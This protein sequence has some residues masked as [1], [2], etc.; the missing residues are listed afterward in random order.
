MFVA[1]A[2]PRTA[3]DPR[4]RRDRHPPCWPLMPI[5]SED[6]RRYGVPVI[7]EDLDDGLLRITGI[8]EKPQAERGPVR[9]RRNRWLRHHARRHRRTTRADQTLVRGRPDREIYLTHAINAY[10][11]RPCRLRPGHPGPLS[12]IPATPPTIWSRS[13]PSRWPIPNTAPVLRDLATQ[14]DGPA[15]ATIA[16]EIGGDR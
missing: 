4:L 14:L 8:V 3:A 6:S 2:A 9:L 7:K 15:T 16:H 10:A 5:A 1:E 11:K 13:S 12:A